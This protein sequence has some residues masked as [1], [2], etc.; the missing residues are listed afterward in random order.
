[1]QAQATAFA[2][3]A[4][5]PT[6]RVPPVNGIR[7]KIVCSM[8]HDDKRRVPWQYFGYPALSDWMASSNDFFVLR[9]FSPV[10]VRCLLYLQNEIAKRDRDLRKWDLFAQ[11][12][13]DGQPD[14]NSGR[15]D[16]D[17]DSLPGH[18]RPRLLR[19][20]IPLLQQY[21]ELVLS[22]SNLKAKTTA[23]EQQI[24]NV[25]NWDGNCGFNTIDEQEQHW[26]GHQ[27]DLITLVSRPRYP[28]VG[29]LNRSLLIRRMFSVEKRSDRIDFESTTYTSN[30]G[31]EAFA[32]FLCLFVGLAMTFGSIWW[33]NFVSN[34]ITRL[35]IITVS[36]TIIAVVA[37]LAAGNRPFEILA[38]FAAYMA[39]LMIY[40]QVERK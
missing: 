23:T 40:L 28:L 22:F 15:V 30:A 33:L 31:L 8:S 34:S 9:R 25:I 5:A 2:D 14:S 19:E 10:Q 17:H 4:Y 24:Q 7:E 1:M 32:T 3:Q 37:W 36:G 27:G 29:L 12:Q 26:R 39:V 11:C 13:G 35:A 6:S 18:P 16:E 21:N 38:T 20:L